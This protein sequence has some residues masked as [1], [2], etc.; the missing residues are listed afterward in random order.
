M[1]NIPQL[2]PQVVAAGICPT[3]TATPSGKAQQAFGASFQHS[4]VGFWEIDFAGTNPTLDPTKV[5]VSVTLGPNMNGAVGYQYAVAQSA[6][7]LWAISTFRSDTN[8]QANCD[9]FVKFELMPS[10][11]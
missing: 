6:G 4:G 5:L 9:L 2:S 1:G 11:T 3:A 8:V 7:P 10:Q